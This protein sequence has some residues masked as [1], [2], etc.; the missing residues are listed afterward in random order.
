MRR[1]IALTNVRAMRILEALTSGCFD[2]FIALFTKTGADT[3]CEQSYLIDP[4]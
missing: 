2:I 3:F 4:K 1:I